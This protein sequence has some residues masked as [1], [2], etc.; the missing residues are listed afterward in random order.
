MAESKRIKRRAPKEGYDNKEKRKYRNK[1]W[2]HLSH[3]ALPIL[4]NNLNA[5]VLMLPSKE[6][7]EIDV[8]IK[9]GIKREQII[10]ID[11]NPALLAHAK[12]KS[13]IPK[14]NRFGCKVS[15]IG[16]KIKKNGWVIAA[17]NLDFCNNFSDELIK[18]IQSFIDSDCL[19]QTS[20]IS[21]TMMRGRESKA[22]L[23]LIKNN[24]ILS[25][26]SEP[27]LI[28]LFEVIDFKGA[29]IR[30][31]YE[32][33]YFESVP[34]CYAIFSL[35]QS[36]KGYNLSQ[37]FPSNILPK[38]TS[39]D[40]T[41]YDDRIEGLGIHIIKDKSFLTGKHYDGRYKDGYYDYDYNRDYI[42]K[43]YWT[44]SELAK[45]DTSPAQLFLPYVVAPVG[46]LAR[47]DIL[48]VYESFLKNTKKCYRSP[49][50]NIPYCVLEN[51]ISCFN[52]NY[53]KDSEFISRNRFLDLLKS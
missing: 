6:G 22:L 19:C 3:N 52:G 20:F 23:R 28:T 24:N 21:I 32:D 7:L 34:I 40:R 35:E 13:K 25:E 30:K 8:A 1:V 47:E 49:Y 12:W 41:F 27:R 29:I 36:N 50:F 5:K 44:F 38:M 48:L 10:A 2:K 4:E 53:V 33:K 17:A 26:F 14:Q 51:G 11:E 16:K 39:C 45:L 31:I 42:T 43:P 46:D 15:D 18:E 9:Y 37:S